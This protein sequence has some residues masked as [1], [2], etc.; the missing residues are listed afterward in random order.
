M[1]RS[2]IVQEAAVTGLTVSDDIVVYT[3]KGLPTDGDRIAELFELLSD[4]AVNID[5]ISQQTCSD[6][7]CAVSF[8][9]SKDKVS[10]I[11]MAFEVNQRMRELEIFKQDDLSLV[12]LVGVG[13]ASHVGVAGRVFSVLAQQNIRHY[14]ITTSEISISVAIDSVQ[15]AAAVVSLS[16]AFSL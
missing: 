1:D 13:M 10:E 14:N 15:K 6:H 2:L 16:E 5:M 3:L 11:D 12:S 9:C 8:S 7:C 4:L